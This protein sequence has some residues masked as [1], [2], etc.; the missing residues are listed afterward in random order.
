[1]KLAR[2]FGYIAGQTVI[3]GIFLLGLTSWIARTL[4]PEGIG[5]YAVTLSVIQVFFC[6]LVY[7]LQPAAAKFI[8]EYRIKGDTERL[9]GLILNLY[10]W[11]IGLGIAS[12]LILYFTKDFISSFYNIEGLG[13][14]LSCGC[15]LVF[16]YGI[17]LLTAS[18]LQGFQKFREL[19]IFQFIYVISSIIAIFIFY[20]KGENILSTLKG[21]G[22]GWAISIL[23]GI[24]VI[25]LSTPFHGWKKINIESL[26]G[27]GRGLMSYA[28]PAGISFI[29]VLLIDNMGTLVVARFVSAAALGWFAFSYRLA[30]YFSKANSVWETLYLPKFSEVFYKEKI[31]GLTALFLNL[32]RNLFFL[33]L[34]A[35]GIILI[36]SPHIIRLMGGEKFMPALVLFRIF[37]LVNI[38]RGMN[39]AINSLYYTCHRTEA[40][41]KVSLSKCLMDIA[42]L[43]WI[44][45]RFGIE[46][47]ALA[48]LSTWVVI[49][50]YNLYLIRKILTVFKA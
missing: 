21:T 42:L 32:M 23:Y 28:L 33:N 41:L 3:V 1:M 11:R 13:E 34:I 12:A 44:V 20:T 31:G 47:A 14:A 18:C 45:P 24:A 7:G 6:L 26:I 43:I 39:P 5:I 19:F 29:F 50:F 36:F 37:V 49:F 48:I 38:I 4:G 15:I 25:A 30:N 40:L 10:I 16:L 22:W 46:A 8:P 35:V 27:Q 2:D 17:F 9:T